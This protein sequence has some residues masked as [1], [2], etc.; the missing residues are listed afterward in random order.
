MSVLDDLRIVV[1]LACGTSDRDDHE[2]RALLHIAVRC[3]NDAN[4][5]TTT[6]HRN[7]P[8][9]RLHRLVEDSRDLTGYQ[10]P[11]KLKDTERAKLDKRA[12]NWDRFHEAYQR[13]EW[14]V[15]MIEAGA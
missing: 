4:R 15:E 3:D 5:L 8:A 13:G 6:N 12:D 14:T 11:V 9:W 7:G 2:Q 1:E 10:K